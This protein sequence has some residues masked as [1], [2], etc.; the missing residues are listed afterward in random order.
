M[1]TTK[2]FTIDVEIYKEFD[3][4]AR[5]NAINKSMFIQNFMKKYTEEKK[6]EAKKESDVK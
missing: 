3:K 5:E 1:K 4:I 6:N 2:T